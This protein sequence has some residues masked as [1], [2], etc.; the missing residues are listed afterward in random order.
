MVTIKKQ[1]MK[2]IYDNY[3]VTVYEF[4]VGYDD[5][6]RQQ[7]INDFKMYGYYV[8]CDNSEYKRYSLETY[9]EESFVKVFFSSNR[10]I[11]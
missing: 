4:L 5:H 1:I 8:H 2:S 10:I 11:I 6:L 9:R 7:I 3:S